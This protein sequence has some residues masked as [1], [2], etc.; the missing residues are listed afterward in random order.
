[1]S[2]KRRTICCVAFLVP[3][4]LCQQ[5]AAR[6]PSG[7]AVAVVQA[8]E[9]TGEVGQ[10]TLQK[11]DAVYMGDRIATESSG[12]AQIIFRDQTKLVV[13]PTSVV[14]VDSF[15][16]NDD[17]SARAVGMSA[18]KGV[19]RFITGVSQ[20]QAY[21]LKTPTATIGVRGTAFDMYVAPNGETAI[22]MFEGEAR[23][24]NRLL[25][26]LGACVDLK[27]GC[28]IVVIGQDGRITRL[29]TLEE[30]TQ[31]LNSEFPYVFSQISLDPAFKVDVSACMVRW[32][33]FDIDASPVSASPH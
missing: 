17:D 11:L 5:S 19:F 14:V 25:G 12:E 6:D 4:I 3:V 13:G 1:M 23:V 30:R 26:R 8:T 24:C 28:S 27:A 2:F 29:N 21:T 22:A 9:V 15:V 18:T 31:R 32:A 33:S 20:K 7:T 10:R 16:F